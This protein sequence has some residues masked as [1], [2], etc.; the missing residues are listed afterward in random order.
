M[1]IFY[2]LNCQTTGDFYDPSTHPMHHAMFMLQFE[3]LYTDIQIS[4]LQ[5]CMHN[6]IEY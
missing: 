2:M 5:R 3:F 6:M 1:R 4:T